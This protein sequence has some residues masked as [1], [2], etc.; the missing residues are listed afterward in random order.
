[1]K[2]H[3]LFVDDEPAVLQAL[4]RV[5]RSHR[6]EW[7]ME[8]FADPAA[9]WERVRRQVP[10]AL[11]TDVRMP[12]MT[13]LELLEAIRSYEP[14]CTLPVVMLTGLGDRDLKRRALELGAADLIRKP[15]DVQQLVARLHNMLRFKSQQDE[16]R[17]YNDLLRR[18]IH[19]QSSALAHGRLNLV[20]RLAKVAEH[21]DEETGNHVVRVGCYSRALARE[22]GMDTEYQQT[23]LV[24]APLHDIGKIGIPD[25]IL[26]K[27]GP[28]SPGEW[29]VMQRH[30]VIGERLLRERPKAIAPLLE[31]FFA[32]DEDLGGDPTIEMSATVALTH[33]EKWDGSGYPLGVAGADIPFESRIVAV[34]DVFDAL[35]SDRPY[36][37]AVG[38]EEA[39]AIIAEGSGS[40]FDPEMVSAF[41]A[42][43]PEIR[44]IAAR[45]HDAA[46]ALVETGGDV[47]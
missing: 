9:A 43:L 41:M 34:C 10:D 27:R 7:E 26:L 22:L 39:L 31:C 1:M 30:C 45:F 2:K 29:A 23:I 47:P 17:A 28:L 40:H 16:L 18:R 8:F 21:R 6:H 11:V 13:G 44:R 20:C 36:K 25:S 19:E 24:A 15:A 38:E 37:R 3:V 5:M 12:G 32:G 35:R 42:V 46:P 33:H 4:Q 14:T